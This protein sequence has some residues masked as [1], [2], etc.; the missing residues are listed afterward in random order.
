MR[1]DGPLI[2]WDDFWKN[3]FKNKDQYLFCD[4]SLFKFIISYG[5]DGKE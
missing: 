2:I 1:I 5:G 4:F 3:D